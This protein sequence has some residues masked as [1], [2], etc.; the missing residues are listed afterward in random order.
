MGS[1]AAVTE[2]GF[3]LRHLGATSA[4]ALRAAPAHGELVMLGAVPPTA[5]IDNTLRVLAILAQLYNGGSN[6][7]NNTSSSLAI[8]DPMAEVLN[9]LKLPGL[10][11]DIKLT[12]PTPGL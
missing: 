6:P 1:T 8:P 4:G 2:P 12:P 5:S 11:G 7:D 9:L 10:F 3:L